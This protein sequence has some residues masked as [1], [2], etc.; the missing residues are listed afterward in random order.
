MCLLREDSGTVCENHPDQP[1]EGPYACQ[2]G[3][4]GMLC[5]KC[6]PSSADEP[7]RLPNGFERDGEL[8]LV[9]RFGELIVPD[10]GTTETTLREAGGTAI[11]NHK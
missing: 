11:H 3:G 6:N 8:R 9:S 1:L 10:D 2:C 7:P 4:A 5:P